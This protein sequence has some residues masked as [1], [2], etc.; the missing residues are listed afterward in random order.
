MDN[1]EGRVVSV[2]A[3]TPHAS[4]VLDVDSS[5]VCPRCAAGRGCGA[6]I[7]G[8]TTGS[9]RRIA[10]AVD[11]GLSVGAGDIV[12]IAMQPANVLLAAFIVYGYPLITAIAAASL[13]WAL[14]LGDLY[15]AVFA[16][17][18]ITLGVLLARWRLANNECLQRLTPVVV[19]RVQSSTQ[20]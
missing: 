11:S 14:Q 15:T 7:F 1:P 8:Q 9:R 4:V 3:G 20:S 18:G 12:R 16:L 17:L 10:A 13:A 6:G 19:E 2:S 5:A